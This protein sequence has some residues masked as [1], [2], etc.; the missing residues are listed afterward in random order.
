MDPAKSA[1]LRAA[2]WFVG[3]SADFLKLTPAERAIAEI[4]V[5]LA[6][7]LRAGR[8]ANGMTQAAL[9][10]AIGS[11]QSR[12]AKMEAGDPSVSLDLIVR[13]LLSIGVSPAM[14]GRMI[15]STTKR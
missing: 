2:G 15:A 6:N 5:A 11:S 13:G 4:H 8:K 3:D 10:L 9:A 12:V 7:A 1:R 14:L